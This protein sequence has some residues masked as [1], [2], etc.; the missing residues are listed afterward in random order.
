MLGSTLA[1]AQ[2]QPVRVIVI[3]VDGLRPD[4]ITAERTPTMFE[5]REEG[6]RAE[7]AVNDAPS[8][9]LPNHATI[10]TGLTSDHHGINFNF[11][12]P[13]EIGVPTLLDYAHDAGYRCAF[14]ATKTKLKYLAHQE[15]L[16]DFF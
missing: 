11:E 4:A 2:P 6:A 1:V 8:M 13:G 3:S 15:K 12:V 10:L 14:F 7:L 5:M 9:T 16:D